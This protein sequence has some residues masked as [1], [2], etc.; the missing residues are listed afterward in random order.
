M[1]GT[2]PPGPARA[3][4]AD[5]RVLSVEQFGAGPFGTRALSDL[6][7]TIIKVEDPAHGGDVARRVPPFQE[8]E[9][10]LYFEAFNAG[11]LSIS[12]DLR[13]VAGREIFDRLAGEVDAI[14]C[15]LRGDKAQR[16][17]IDYES[18]RHHNPGIVCAS[19]S[20]F[21]QTGPRAGEP[22]YDYVLQAMAGWMSLTGEPDG[23]PTKS[24]L[25]LVDFSAGYAMAL[26]LLAA[27][28]RARRDG[29]GGDCDLSLFE[30]ALSM[31]AYVGTWAA[32]EGYEP[33]RSG[34]RP[35]HRSSRSRRS[36]R[37]TA[38]SPSPARRRSSGSSSVRRWDSRS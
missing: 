24:G 19:L 35:I 11:K 12:L 21:G 17:G 36:P 1:N 38:G 37:P 29:V 30:V 33:P 28:W 32:S 4:L 15:N 31:L 20:G 7:A 10:S 16:L 6:G 13:T 22:A 8:G 14:A 2:E 23:P 34:N 25:S 9:D 18:Q 26:A 3:P 5:L 27:V